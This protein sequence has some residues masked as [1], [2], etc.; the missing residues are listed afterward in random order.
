MYIAL[1]TGSRERNIIININE[2]KH[3][4]SPVHQ[5]E[6]M[7]AFIGNFSKVC[8]SWHI[9]NLT[10]SGCCFLRSLPGI[11]RGSSNL[12]R[13]LENLDKPDKRVCHQE[14]E[15]AES[16]WGEPQKSQK[17]K[18]TGWLLLYHIHRDTGR[19][20]DTRGSVGVTMRETGMFASIAY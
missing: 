9:L 17:K 16:T 7:E 1:L 11:S 5:L 19:K 15:E 12:I 4:S 14:E 2:L 18:C 20:H 3:E 10:L 6:S 8:T 13:R